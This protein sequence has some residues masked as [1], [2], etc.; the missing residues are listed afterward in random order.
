MRTGEDAVVIEGAGIGVNVVFHV[1]TPRLSRELEGP[2]TL[3]EEGGSVLLTLD[4]KMRE[5]DSERFEVLI[6][7][8]PDKQ[9]AGKVNK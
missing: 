9:E 6:T 5:A 1:L 8:R 3:A 2:R 4:G 7:T